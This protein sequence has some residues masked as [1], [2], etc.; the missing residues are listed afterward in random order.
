MTSQP[1]VLCA[2]IVVADHVCTPISHVPAAGELVMADGMLLTSGGCAANA[3]ID[4]AKIGVRAAVVGRVGADLF[5][6]IVSD[7]LR[8]SGVDVSLVM[9]TPGMDTSQTMIVNVAGQDRRFIHT[10]GANARFAAADIPSDRLISC[11]V[12]YLGGYLLTPNL[13]QEELV[14]V[15]QKARAHGVKTVLDVGVP[16]PGEYVSRLDRLLPFTDVFLPN[17]H[18]G[19]LITGERDPVK[20]AEIF[21]R[22]GAR[23][24]VITMGGDGSILVQKDLRLK[25]GV[26]PID[27]V[28]GSGGG[29]AF[30]AGY[31]FGMLQ[32][33]GAEDCLRFAS[34]LGASCVR[35]I[36]TTPG[37][38]TRPECEEFL[39]KNKLSIHR[40]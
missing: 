24:V 6:R 2:G 9:P 35:A 27:Y 23:T 31:I 30:D 36:G 19:E 29:D 15:F 14:P 10:F 12:L 4:L 11:K 38:F 34:A 37:V 5:G 1:D 22:L 3:A 8:D 33:M 40:L 13:K 17:N 16:K 26:Y 18:E 39:A 28:D 32:N 20:Q 7:M 21:Q 25:A